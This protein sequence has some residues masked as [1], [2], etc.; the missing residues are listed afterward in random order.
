[1]RRVLAVALLAGGLVLAAEPPAAAAAPTLTVSPRTGLVDDQPILIGIRN[2]TG[3][4]SLVAELCPVGD[5]PRVDE[6]DYLS[7]IDPGPAGNLRVRRPADVIVDR[8]TQPPVDCRVSACELVVWDVNGG[9]LPNNVR[10]RVPLSFDPGGPDPGRPTFSASPDDDLRHGDEVRVTGQA[11]PV[12]AFRSPPAEAQVGAEPEGDEGPVR[13]VSIYQCRADPQD[14]RD[15]HQSDTQAPMTPAG[16]FGRRVT[17]RSRLYTDSGATI[18]CLAEACVLAA[19]N[20]WE[21]SE[22]GVAPI[23]FDPEGPIAP[24]PTVTVTPDSDLVDGQ[25]VTITAEHF[26]PDRHL[27]LALCPPDVSGYVW[28]GCHEASDFSYRS[29]GT[30]AVTT[31]HVVHA[32]W[33]RPA[34]DCREVSCSFVVT[35]GSDVDDAPRASIALD[36]DAPRLDRRVT[37]S[38]PNGLVGGQRVTV[39]AENLYPNDFSRVEQCVVQRGDPADAYPCADIDQLVRH[40]QSPT[41][42][43]TTTFKA[44]RHPYIGDGRIDCL[45]RH[46][47]VAV[48][49]PENGRIRGP[50]LVFSP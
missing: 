35:W 22:A 29:D 2:W 27:T 7:R 44:R 1:V 10:R 26:E 13:P 14:F 21:L 17:I 46:C 4:I 8:V 9:H 47:Y 12:P 24:P 37:V 42:F 28:S 40:R 48:W 25:V 5:N 41:S 39:T 20:N 32:T 49:D 38:P 23:T 18:D 3:A 43:T 15:C 34:F 33:D 11:F 6:C 36:P 16:N 45:R 30:G 50:R 19:T 31:Q